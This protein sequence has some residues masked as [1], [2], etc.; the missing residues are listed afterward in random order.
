MAEDENEEKLL[1][2]VALQNAQSILLARQRAERELIEA[3]ETLER[4]THELAHSLAMVRATLESTTDGILVTNAQG[5]VT[6][7]NQ[8]FADMWRLPREVMETREHP[9]LL[10]VTAPQLKDPHKF[11]ARIEEIYASSPPETFDQLELS[12]GRVLERFSKI[13]FVEE[14]NVG[15]VWSFRDITERKQ[16]EKSLRE[17]DRRKDEFLAIL[18]HEL[19]NPLGVISNIAQVMRK[20][21]AWVDSGLEELEEAM[22]RQVGQMARLLDDLL[23]VSRVAR[24]QI[25]LKKEPCDLTEIVG[26][27]AEDHRSLLEE[28]GLLLLIELPDT[29]LWVIGDPTRLA[30]IVGN[31]LHNANKFT[32]SGGRV[33]VRLQKMQSREEALLTVRDTG[34]GMEPVML[35]HAFEPFSQ[36]EHSID[37][38][39]GGLGLGLA[40]VKGLVELQGGKVAIKSDGPGLGVELAIRFPLTEAPAQA[41][42]PVEPMYDGAR[43]CRI[44]IIEDNQ[45]AAKS[46]KMFLAASGHTVEVAHDGQTGIETARRF[47]PEVVLCD[48]GLPVM[49]GYA[50]CQAL[51]K[52]PGLNDA[53][54]IAITGYGQEED[55]RRTR[56]V[57]F[58]AHLT[59]PVDLDDVER[60]LGRFTAQESKAKRFA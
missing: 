3:K 27:A 58:D 24:G 5:E 49:D 25:R 19:R 42:K 12:D 26:K 43:A 1:R 14:R 59:K 9:Q 15:R 29:P 16:S 52:E 41:A 35:A 50:V 32:D 36:A 45:V 53:F 2:S 37:R 54:L 23:D 10:E 34:I 7:F 30:Q 47:R 38:S 51:R 22:T 40:L 6:G 39:R 31:T 56:D 4:K 48:I 8:K 33:T 44:L 55:E 46:T 17:A 18:S 57:G 11:R 21:K 60:L 20:K 13:Q 28:N